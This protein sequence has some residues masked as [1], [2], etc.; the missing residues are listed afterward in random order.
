MTTLQENNRC[1]AIIFIPGLSDELTDQ[2]IEGIAQ[3]IGAS[4]QYETS[5]QTQLHTEALE[6]NPE[7]IPTTSTEN[8]SLSKTRMI[9]ISAKDQ[10]S[11]DTTVD[12]YKLDYNN[13]FVH[14]Y[15]ESSLFYKTFRLLVLLIYGIPILISSFRSKNNAKSSLEKCQLL[16]GIVLFSVFV[17]YMVI[18]LIAVFGT[19]GAFDT[20]LLAP[21]FA[22]SEGIIV[23][24]ALL[25]SLRPNIRQFS[26]KIIVN[27]ICLLEYLNF[28][29]RRNVISGQLTNLLEY[30]GNKTAYQHIHIVSY[31]FGTIIAL[32]NLFPLNEL[33]N[34]R[35][36]IVN[37]L[38]TIG[39]PFD[40][41]RFFW[42][43]YF[44]RR[45]VL[46]KETPKWIN[47]Y[48]P[49]DILSSNFRDDEELK[50]A[51]VGIRLV[52]SDIIVK[53]NENI[54]HIDSVNIVE[55]LNLHRY[56][57]SLFVLLSFLFRIRSHFIYWR[58][59]YENEKDCFSILVSFIYRL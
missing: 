50:E 32:D 30:I 53:P 31:S 33:P 16:F 27:Y 49:N 21:I 14:N 23:F 15:S 56:L 57:K 10:T 6:Y 40:I 58:K 28:G 24:L 8:P 54:A 5:A 59:K 19:L 17:A 35:T 1:D 3:R 39:C 38:I 2:S 36:P 46:L 51:Q 52:N 43:S 26:E 13:D 47:L 9:R 7:S 41:V 37:T 25:E 48:N 20:T 42:K 12:V 55:E 4:L 44:N 34:K 29:K 18:L 22:S 11:V 45:Q